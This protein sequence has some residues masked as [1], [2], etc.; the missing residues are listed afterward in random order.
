[1]KENMA[2]VGID[3]ELNGLSRSGYFDAVRSGQHH[4]QNWWDTGT[5]P[6]I[7][8]ILFHSSNAGG[9]TNRNNYINEEMD[10][11]IDEA[12]GSP[13]RPS[14]PSCTSRSRRR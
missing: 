3:V 7:V 6:D 11:L 10:K 2:K 14:A 12:A 1:M 8:R 5:D 13:T 4:T 9:G